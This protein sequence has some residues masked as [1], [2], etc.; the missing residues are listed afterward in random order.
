VF[1]KP[2]GC[3][4]FTTCAFFM[5]GRR[6]GVG[7][8]APEQIAAFSDISKKSGSCACEDPSNG[9]TVLSHTALVFLFGTKLFP[10]SFVFGFEAWKLPDVATM[11]YFL[12]VPRDRLEL[13]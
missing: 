13:S 9:L 3:N 8:N 7:A 10:G 1:A 12:A 5:S 6:R 11:N 2:L 4:D